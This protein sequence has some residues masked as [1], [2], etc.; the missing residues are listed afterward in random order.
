M[1]DPVPGLLPSSGDGQCPSASR[2]GGSRGLGVEVD[3]R[4]AVGSNVGR[5][6]PRINAEPMERRADS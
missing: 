6:L 4:G 3:A 2:G 5:G 1:P